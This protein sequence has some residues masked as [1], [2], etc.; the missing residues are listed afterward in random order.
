MVML[1]WIAI[2]NAILWSGVITLLLLS[3]LR[4]SREVEAQAARLEA[5]PLEKNEN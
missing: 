2:A 1:I 3:L 4:S 5:Q